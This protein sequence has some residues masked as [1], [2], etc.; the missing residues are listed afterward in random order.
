MGPV[1]RYVVTT[2]EDGTI[3]SV[4][5]LPMRPVQE[6]DLL[7]RRRWNLVARF[8]KTKAQQEELVSQQ[9]RTA[10]AIREADN[11]IQDLTSSW[12]PHFMVP[13]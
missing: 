4:K 3:L 13:S 9:S 1:K 10:R 8:N 6:L 11:D 2:F 7:K 5:K 12:P